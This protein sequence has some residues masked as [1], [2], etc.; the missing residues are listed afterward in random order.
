[1]Q[2]AIGA[3]VADP[4]AGFLQVREPLPATS[5]HVTRRFEEL[6]AAAAGPARV[7]FD[8][9]PAKGARA[10]RR[11][12]PYHIVARSGRYYLVAY[13]LARR[14]WRLFAV[15]AI[16]DA[17][18]REGTFTRRTV[19]ERFLSERAV[20]WI[21]GPRGGDVTVA[22]S[23]LIAVAVGARTWQQGQRFTFTP[24]GGAQITLRFEDLSEAVRWALQFGTE[25]TVVGPPEA[26]L[27]A[28]ETA[29]RIAQAYALAVGERAE[30]RKTA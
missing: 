18:V 6:K 12:E 3:T 16:G 9:T 20:G 17:I 5:D 10:R 7:E 27:L 2:D 24:D 22:L 15:D 26:V 28:L 23:A 11:V 14:D 21:T 1:M 25:A 29:A 19:P 30:G 8:Y 4:R 13:D